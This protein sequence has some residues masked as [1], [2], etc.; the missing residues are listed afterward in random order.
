MHLA[1]RAVQRNSD[2]GPSPQPAGDDAPPRV[3][4]LGGEPP[5]VAEVLGGRVP[6]DEELVKAGPFLPG[7]RPSESAVLAPESPLRVSGMAESPFHVGI[8][9]RYSESAV[10]AGLLLARPF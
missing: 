10:L 5:A 4:A 3:L 2:A 9:S 7:A 8:P 6:A 1:R